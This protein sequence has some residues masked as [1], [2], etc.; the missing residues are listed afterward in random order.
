LKLPHQD[1]A[2]VDVFG[3]PEGDHI[4]AIL[5]RRT[6]SHNYTK[7]SSDGRKVPHF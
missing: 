4:D 5:L 1:L 3:A 7:T 2:I 6:G